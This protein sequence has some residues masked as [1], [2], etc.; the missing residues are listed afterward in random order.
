M[1]NDEV[2]KR[3]LVCEYER[4]FLAGKSEANRQSLY[5]THE[6]LKEERQETQANKLDTE[7]LDWIEAAYADLDET[8]DG[9][10]C[11]PWETGS[12]HGKTAREAIDAAIENAKPE[13]PNP[14]PEPEA[15]WPGQFP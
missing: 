14:E 15:P 5:Q 8:E 4:G 13:Q 11:Y 3:A 9:W 7:R 1:S 2:I 12:A 6:A 10:T